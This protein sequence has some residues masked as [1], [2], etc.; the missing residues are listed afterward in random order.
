MADWVKIIW[1]NLEISCGF[2]ILNLLRHQLTQSFPQVV[3]RWEKLQ[4]FMSNTS[5]PVHTQPQ[6]DR[7]M[8]NHDIPM[9]L[10]ENGDL[11]DINGY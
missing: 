6:A 11:M 8:K 9:S 2:R 10:M 5:V 4:R 3:R 1:N 7:Q